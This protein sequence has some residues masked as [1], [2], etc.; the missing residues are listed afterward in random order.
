MMCNLGFMLAEGIFS[1]IRLSCWRWRETRIH[2]SLQIFVQSLEHWQVVEV[3]CSMLRHRNLIRKI[4]LA[5]EAAVIRESVPTRPSEAVQSGIT[6]NC[7][8]LTLKSA[9]NLN[10]WLEYAITS[11]K[12]C[13]SIYQ[14]SWLI[15]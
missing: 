1:T 5:C 10:V 12:L 3:E 6:G 8:D 13:C 2:P 15:G 14:P 11:T 7:Q 9:D 4:N